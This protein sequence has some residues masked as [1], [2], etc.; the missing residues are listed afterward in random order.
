MNW[1]RANVL[2]NRAPLEPSQ[3]RKILAQLV[4]AQVFEEFCADKFSAATHFSLEGAESLICGLDSILDR[5]SQ[6]GVLALEM[7]MAHRGRLNVLANVLEIPLSALLDR[8][9]R[10]LDDLDW[11]PNNSDD[12][13]YH[14]GASVLRQTSPDSPAVRLSLAANPSH[15]EA[16]NGVVLGKAR[17]RQFLIAHRDR[18]SKEARP[19]AEARRKVM[20]LLLHGDASFFQGSVRESLGFSNLRDYTTGGTVH[21][22]VN[23]Q[24]GFTTLPKQAH[25]STYCSDVAKSVG[26]P[27]LHVN[28][29]SP[30]DVVR[31]FARAVDYRQEFGG[32]IVI[33]LWC[34]RRRGHNQRDAP[35]VTQPAMYSAIRKHPTVARK[36]AAALGVD[37]DVELRQTRSDIESRV[38]AVQRE[39]LRAMSGKDAAFLGDDNTETR[40]RALWNE[41]QAKDDPGR[42]VRV[43][44]CFG[45]RDERQSGVPVE[46][47]AR[48]AQRM[49]ALPAEFSAHAKVAQVM[50]KRLRTVATGDGVRWDTAEALALGS[51]LLDGVDVRLAGQDVERGTFNQ[52]HAVLYALGADGNETSYEPWTALLGE[53]PTSPTRVGMLSVVNSPLSEESVLA[54]EHGYSLYSS[55]VLGIWEAQ[56]GDFANCAQT[57]IDTFLASGEEKWARQSGLVLLLPHGF[58]GQGPDH[59][60]A[61][62][63]RF[64]ALCSEDDAPAPAVLEGE[65]DS[66]ASR[67]GVNMVVANPSTPAQFFHL[68]RRH[69][70]ADFRK[71]LIVFTPKFLLHH[72]PCTSKLDDMAPGTQF[73]V[74]LP[75][76]GQGGRPLRRIVL[77]SGKLWFHLAEERAKADAQGD[78]ALVRVEQLA[79]FPFAALKRE[80]A[81]LDPHGRADVVWAQEEPKNKGAWAFVAPRLAHVLGPSQAAARYVGRPPSASPATGSYNRHKRELQR[82][83]DR[84]LF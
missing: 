79:P 15:L 72:I 5:A 18:A 51:L 33:N 59:S 53:K 32:D 14:L 19:D 84:V 49:F 24:I 37:A 68:L 12:V 1:I 17:A 11:L 69:V 7:G 58:D 38:L 39:L 13:R 82:L 23:N 70:I 78:V 30:E 75:D 28:A 44:D 2:H 6:H 67:M 55:G 46:R 81:R 54:F 25:S 9:E 65:E 40:V 52:R 50:E 41:R 47:L 63:E 56:F 64:L 57:V 45:G 42:V 77:C 83:I 10:Y 34:Y 61:F 21:V 20:P 80:I 4:Q 48:I 27:V 35:E 16:V 62:I 29:D 26:A 71:P 74:V 73:K 76:D 43:A 31:A 66:R 3:Q 8:F 22:I 60:S 36:Y